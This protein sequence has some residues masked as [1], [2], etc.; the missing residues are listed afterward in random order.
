MLPPLEL[1]AAGLVRE[2]RCREITFLHAF[3]TLFRRIVQAVGPGEPLD[4]LSIV[5]LTGERA[6]WSDFDEFRRVCP[7]DSF[8]C[9]GLAS[10]ECQSHIYWFVDERMRAS[11]PQ[12]PVGTAVPDRNVTMVGE[13]GRPV[14][15]GE[16]GEVVVSSRYIASGYWNATDLTRQAFNIDPA[17]SESRMFRTGDLGRWRGG[18]FEYVGR[19]DEQVKLRGYR[20]HPAEIENVL[21]SFPE[22]AEAAIVVRRNSDGTAR[23]LSAY[24]TLGPEVQGL[25]PRHLAAMLQQRLRSHLVPWPIF[26]VDDLPRLPGLK[27]DRAHLAEMDAERSAAGSGQ[28]ENEVVAEVIRVFE[29]IIGVSGAT[30][31]DNIAS[32]GGDSLQAVDIAAELERRFGV[33]ISD[34][35]M[36]SAQTIAALASWIADQQASA[37]SPR[38]KPSAG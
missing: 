21:M 30:A 37:M 7:A 35:T 11:H 9:I 17:D 25:L 38:S 29:Q 34:E 12:L 5:Y 32:L 8:L 4:D 20:V 19:K 22:V 27:I 16:I 24:I 1:N 15:D 2:L 36:A 33:T 26:V 13:D 14:A 3:P 23:S 31:D 18:L 10:S 28:V 6:S